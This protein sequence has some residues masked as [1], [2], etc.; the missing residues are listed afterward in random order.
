MSFRAYFEFGRTLET[1]NDIVR[2]VL[3]K[4]KKY[5]WIKS[6]YFVGYFLTLYGSYGATGS[7]TQILYNEYYKTKERPWQRNKTPYKDRMDYIRQEWG[8]LKEQ[9]A[10]ML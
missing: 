7:T 3:V 4:Y 8:H 2:I 1:V 10:H 9:H 6:I 5:I